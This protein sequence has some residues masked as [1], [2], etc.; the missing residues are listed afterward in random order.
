MKHSKKEKSSRTQKGF[1]KG[2]DNN[3]IKRI[4]PVMIEDIMMETEPFK[5]NDVTIREMMI[6]TDPTN[7]NSPVI[8]KRFKPLNNPSTVLEVLQGILVIKEGVV[9][10]N[11]TTG[12]NMYAYWRGCLEGNA[13]RKF[14]ELTTQVGTE[15]IGHLSQVE[16]RLVTF[17]SPK[18]VLT[19]QTRYIR[20]KMRMPRGVTTK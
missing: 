17:Y 18:E 2:K 16:Q 6:R 7:D 12:P 8:K 13:L 1:S 10:N 11:V 14:Q 3:A 4:A 5:K 19:Q 15:T 20:T 9:G